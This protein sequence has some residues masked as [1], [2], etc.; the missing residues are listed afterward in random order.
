MKDAWQSLTSAT[1]LRQSD[2]QLKPGLL[3]LPGLLS[4]QKSIYMPVK[5]NSLQQ[6]PVCPTMSKTLWTPM[7]QYGLVVM[8]YRFTD[9]FAPSMVQWLA[10]LEYESLVTGF[11]SGFPIS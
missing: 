2:K 10:C 6:S 5:Q 3:D 9:V 7:F 8:L 1:Q 11:V 4:L